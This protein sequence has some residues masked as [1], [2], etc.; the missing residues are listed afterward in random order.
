M[1]LIRPGVVR[2]LV[3]ASSAPQDAARMHGWAADRRGQQR[4][5]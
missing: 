5:V 1:A 2:S 3:L 4:D